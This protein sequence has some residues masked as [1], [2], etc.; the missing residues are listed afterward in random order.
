[1]TCRAAFAL[2]A[3][4]F[5]A[6]AQSSLAQVLPGT[7]PMRPRMLFTVN[8]IPALQA[9]TGVGGPVTDA[10]NA[11]RPGPEWLCGS[12]GGNCGGKQVHWRMDRTARYMLELAAR[13]AITGNVASGQGAVQTLVG[14]GSN[15][16]VGWVR[17]AGR[18]SGVWG[19]Y[20]EGAL[21]AASAATYDMVRPLLSNSQ[22][23]QVVAWLESW[24][25]GFRTQTNGVGPYSLYG[26][27]TDNH[28][29]AWECG[30]SM[31]L[32]AIWGDSSRSNIPAQID[33][34]LRRIRDGHMDVFSPDG[35]YDEGHGYLNY[36]GAYAVRALIAGRNCGFADYLQGS[37]VLKAPRWYL[38]LNSDGLF[39]LH[40][41]T[42]SRHR[43]QKWDPIMYFLA[44]ESGDEEAL[45]AL[46]ELALVRPVNEDSDSQGFSPYLTT[47]LHFPVGM[48]S[49][50]PRV[51]S[52]FFRDNR[53]RTP[54]GDPFWNKTNNEPGLGL[55][56]TAYLHAMV[57][58][59][60]VFSANFIIRDEWMSHAHEDDG[61][62]GVI[63]NGEAL[64]LDPGTSSNL[65][66][67]SYWGSQSLQH[68]I[69]SADRA[70]F[71]GTGT[72]HFRPP[73]PEGRFLGER[74]ASLLGVGADYVRGDHRFMWMMERAERSLFMVKDGDWPLLLV[75]DRVRRGGGAT[76]YEQRWHTPQAMTGNGSV[77]TP[78]EV[79]GNRGRLHGI[80]LTPNGLTRV[81]S[82]RLV[83]SATNLGLY[84]N[85]L[86]TSAVNETDILTLWSPARVSSLTPL[87]GPVGETRGG[88]VGWASG[89]QDHLLVSAG[90]SASDATVTTDARLAWIRRSG[91]AVSAYSLAEGSLMSDGAT[92]LV[93][94]SESIS[95]MV[96]GGVVDLTRELGSRGATFGGL[97]EL[98][99]P[100]GMGVTEVFLDG[101]P[102]TGWAVNGNLL[103]IGA[104]PPR[105][106]P[107][108]E[109]PYT[110]DRH[111]RFDP[112]VLSTGVFSGMAYRTTQG[113]LATRDPLVPGTFRPLPAGVWYDAQS[114]WVAF[115]VR[116]GAGPAGQLGAVHIDD[117]N[118]QRLIT[119]SVWD[120]P[121]SG[122]FATR[123]LFGTGPAITNGAFV[124]NVAALATEADVRIGME[125]D[126]AGG[127]L[128]FFDR[129]GNLVGTSGFQAIPDRVVPIFEVNGEARWDDVTVLD[130]LERPGT[131]QG[132]VAWIDA[133]GRLGF[134]VGSPMVF[135]LQ[136]VQ[137]D[138]EGLRLEIGEV[139]S[140]L[141]MFGFTEELIAPFLVGGMVTPTLR[142]MSWNSTV[143]IPSTQ[144]IGANHVFDLVTAAQDRLVEGTE[145]L[146]PGTPR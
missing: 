137:L 142:E 108:G 45:F 121:T 79:R 110:L 127:N 18:P 146:P 40:G 50:A 51:R 91:G 94:A 114:L 145:Q 28:S 136:D 128:R 144:L 17:P 122:T 123:T 107:A 32:M 22:R 61:H 97:I 138:I 80:A 116:P 96:G 4:L 125:F 2:V 44:A 10:W 75:H 7:P 90:G 6:S 69:V 84:R 30:I 83:N 53:N 131:P 52:Q 105:T 129:G 111:E 133:G 35:S 72:N 95:V 16:M 36:G 39:P 65:A 100:T 63:L 48:T 25:D 9:R 113:E 74:K 141:T 71:L 143:P 140:V 38:G 102:L 126:L 139:I 43:S 12:G 37:N 134:Y 77:A 29:F 5:A 88:I 81:T 68:N 109:P 55:G 27:A 87:A 64:F 106:L 119:I 86:R 54:T 104:P 132:L 118:G 49:R 26:A 59:A 41:D 42:S 101:E 76:I 99:V 15:S 89:V 120:N 31:A 70:S 1:M 135:G 11:F 115:D 93:A 92:T 56:G 20:R 57:P 112:T 124:V 85:E 82:S 98:H 34:S 13:Y 23:N 8:D 66:N 130:D 67:P 33:E 62:V 21:V 73:A 19:A 46:E 117:E 47:F 14:G 3:I 78:F 58:G 60:P 24:I 103:R